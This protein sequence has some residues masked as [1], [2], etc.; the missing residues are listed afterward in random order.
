ME[1]QVKWFSEQKGYG[2]II[3]E[4]GIERFF[5]IRDI[6]GVELPHN[7]DTVS[8]EPAEGEKG[9]KAANVSITW[10]ADHRVDDRPIC[11]SCGRKMTPRIIPG[12]PLVHGQGSWTPVPKKSIFPFCGSIY[13]EFPASTG[14][15]IGQAIFII[16]LIVIAGHFII[17]YLSR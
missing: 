1:G 12:S 6:A 9:P 16:I 11:D 10:K 4:D 3:G 5:G 14:E 15:K 2:F 17:R 7:E 13:Q 8:F